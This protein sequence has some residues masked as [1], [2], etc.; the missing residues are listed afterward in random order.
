MIRVVASQRLLVWP[1]TLALALVGTQLAHWVAYR[2]VEPSPVDRAHGLT[3]ASHGYLSHLPLALAVCAVVVAS[4][5]AARIRQVAA[6]PAGVRLDANV[7]RFAVL[8]PAIFILQEHLERIVYAG[9]FPWGIADTPTFMLGL[10]L[11]FPFALAA[12]LVARYLLR[13]AHAIG[14]LIT[15]VRRTAFVAVRRPHPQLFTPRRAALARGYGSRGPPAVE[16]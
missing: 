9:A 3:A 16:L 13:I 11:Q 7:G 12:Y 14:R 5:L 2:A 4:A 1:I 6:A 10:V 8:A 15:P